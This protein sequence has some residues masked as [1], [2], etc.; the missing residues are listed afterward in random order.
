M[1]S[2]SFKVKPES[3][4]IIKIKY[5]MILQNFKTNPQAGRFSKP[6]KV[7]RKKY[8]QKYLNEQELAANWSVSNQSPTE[9]IDSLS[10]K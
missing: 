10:V 1:E 6:L 5:T 7:K 9:T 8:Q 4:R 2:L 3:S